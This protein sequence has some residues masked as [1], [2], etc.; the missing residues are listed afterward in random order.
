[1]VRVLHV[2]MVEFCHDFRVD[3]NH[4]CALDLLFGGQSDTD[5]FRRK[6]I[7]ATSEMICSDLCVRH[8]VRSEPLRNGRLGNGLPASP[9]LPYQ[10]SVR[11]GREDSAWDGTYVPVRFFDSSSQP[12]QNP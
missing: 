12:S 8:T 11:Q 7:A 5:S 6:G 10:R 9:R 2:P 4:Q 3:S 1:M